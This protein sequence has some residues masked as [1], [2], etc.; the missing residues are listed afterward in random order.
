MIAMGRSVP[1]SPGTFVR[2]E[3]AIIRLRRAR[4]GRMAPSSG[5]S[6]RFAANPSIASSIGQGLS[7]D[8]AQVYKILTDYLKK[9]TVNALLG[10]SRENFAS[11]DRIAIRITPVKD[12]PA[13]FAPAPGT[14]APAL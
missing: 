14:P 12:L 2:W 8:Q 1:P 9:Y 5:S 4:R 10:P 11:G 3:S 7:F 13:E 6:A